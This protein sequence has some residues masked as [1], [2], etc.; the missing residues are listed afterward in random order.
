MVQYAGEEVIPMVQ[1]VFNE[2]KLAAEFAQRVIEQVPA[3]GWGRSGET[4]FC[5]ALAAAL[6]ATDH[7]VSYDD[8]MGYTGLAFRMR[9]Y[10]GPAGKQR[11]CPSS[12]VGEFPDEIAAAGRA[13]GWTLRTEAHMEAPEGANMG[14]F[15]GQI[16]ESIDAGRPVLAYESR[17]NMAVIHGYRDGGRTL[18][19][20]DYFRGES[21]GGASAVEAEKIGPMLVFL[22]QPATPPPAK[23]SVL[24]GLR[25][26]LRSAARHEHRYGRRYLVRRRG[27]RPMGR[28][29]AGDAR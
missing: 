18:L 23:Q 3:L 4:T 16:V 27:I 9:W 21:D 28:G 5:G 14:R 25:R 20:R 29:S 11:W 26:Q 6:K 22:E 10:Q 24:A 1:E 13:S 2:H 12:P 8:L 19:M 17:M 15:A 7:P